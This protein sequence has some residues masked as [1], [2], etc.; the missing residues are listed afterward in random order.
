MPG[1]KLNNNTDCCGAI[2][3]YQINTTTIVKVIY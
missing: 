2:D 1:I 3:K